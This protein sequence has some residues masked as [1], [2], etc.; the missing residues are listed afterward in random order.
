MNTSVE[1][2]HQHLQL[3]PTSGSNNMSI[4]VQ[5]YSSFPGTCVVTS[6]ESLIT[7]LND[8]FAH[9]NEKTSGLPS[10]P[11]R[12][13]PTVPPPW[14]S[15]APSPVLR[16]TRLRTWCVARSCRLRTRFEH[17]R[18]Q[19]FS[20]PQNTHIICVMDARSRNQ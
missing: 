9:N 13:P 3:I 16:G 4:L 19:V 6:C 20:K 5:Q 12:S 11:I 15:Q 2:Q 8:R 17:S 10:E 14:S 1:H 7:F 18:F